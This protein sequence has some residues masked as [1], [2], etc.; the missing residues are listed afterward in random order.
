MYSKPILS[1]AKAT[2]PSVGSNWGA[3]LAGAF[4]FSALLLAPL[5][6][7]AQA[8]TPDHNADRESLA[9]RH[10]LGEAGKSL[11]APS[12]GR[13]R[14]AT[15]TNSDGA[16]D[17]YEW[18]ESLV[19][20]RA[21]QASAK[22]A[23]ELGLSVTTDA[24]EHSLKFTAE[25]GW[26]KVAYDTNND[27]I[28]DSYEY[29]LSSA[30]DVAREA[31]K[32]MLAET[33]KPK[34]ILGAGGF[35][36]A[37]VPAAPPERIVGT[38][39]DLSTSGATAEEAPHIVARIRTSDGRNVVADLGAASQLS[40]LELKQADKITVSGFRS[41]L[42]EPGTL[43]VEKIESDRGAVS[44][45]RIDAASPFRVD[46]QIAALDTAR[47]K[48]FEKEHMIAR[49]KM[50]EDREMQVD[51]GPKERMLDMH[52]AAGAKV[53]VLATRIQIDGEPS[54]QAEKLRLTLADG[55]MAMAPM[56]NDLEPGTHMIINRI[57]DRGFEQ[58]DKV[59]EKSP[60]TDEPSVKPSDLP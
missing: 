39:Q 25:K 3:R 9:E 45:V 51:L 54:L 40:K 26:I 24:K 34:K 42:D 21:R 46:G 47:F 28:V 11:N 49:I 53:S 13:T 31:T 8:A 58:I 19:F 12:Y 6:V 44:I 7:M 57:R 59:P 1:S 52:L 2:H 50:G 41:N 37:L 14:I 22:Q 5:S 55:T 23:H 30:L 15:P 36:A 17:K 33:P 20:Q 35:A 16:A 60:A 56:S 32:K 4:A 27:G 29:M 48:G 43:M 18:I 10:V 38:I